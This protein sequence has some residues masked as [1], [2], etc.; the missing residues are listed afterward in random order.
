MKYGTCW[1]SGT[2]EGTP[3]IKLAEHLAILAD[4]LLAR[5]RRKD[6]KNASEIAAWID[7]LRAG[8]WESWRAPLALVGPFTWEDFERV[9]EAACGRVPAEHRL[10]V[11][12]A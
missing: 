5:G 9:K 4:A 10:F 1:I 11:P 2:S 3:L 7:A 12:K 6:I 8:T